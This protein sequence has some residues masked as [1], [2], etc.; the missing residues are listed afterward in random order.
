MPND[1]DRP[2]TFGSREARDD[3]KEPSQ[4]SLSQAAER[5]VG[6]FTLRGTLLLNQNGPAPETREQYI[7]DLA[8][9]MT[10]YRFEE[11]GLFSMPTELPDS[12]T[13]HRER[14]MDE[15]AGEVLRARAR[16]PGV[17]HRWVQDSVERLRKTLEE[18]DTRAEAVMTYE[19]ERQNPQ[20]VSPSERIRWA[21]LAARLGKEVEKWHQA[22]QESLDYVYQRVML[23]HL[24]WTDCRGWGRVR[25]YLEECLQA[26]I[27]QAA[28]TYTTDAVAAVQRVYDELRKPPWAGLANWWTEGGG[29]DNQEKTDEPVDALPPSE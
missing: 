7:R 6:Q 8:D 27:E 29:A 4:R 23:I 3:D 1:G 5:G 20:D 19:L 26:L 22:T 25:P 11:L 16:Y 28:T 21:A 2:L 12:M 13:A 18:V 14:L 24:M 10:S 15:Y 9:G 17:G